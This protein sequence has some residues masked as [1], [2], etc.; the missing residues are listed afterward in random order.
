MKNLKSDEVL[1]LI[2]KKVE[3][4]KNL[5]LAKKQGKDEQVANLSKKIQQLEHELHSRPLA[6]N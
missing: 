6:K 5:K 2:S 4:K 1:K 3:Y